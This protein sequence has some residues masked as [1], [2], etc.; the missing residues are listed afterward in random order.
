MV[1][2]VFLENS[3]S[4]EIEKDNFDLTKGGIEEWLK[5]KKII[6]IYSKL[7]S[8]KDVT[9]WQRGGAE[10]YLTKFS[11]SYTFKNDLIFKNILIKALVTINPENAL[12]DWYNRREY[13]KKNNVKVSNWYWY[14]NGIIIEDFYYYSYQ[15]ASLFDLIK[16]AKTID[17][18]GFKTTNFL[19][20]IMCDINSVPYY[21]D[22]GF[23]LG[24]YGNANTNDAINLLIQKNKSKEKEIILLLKNL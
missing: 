17:H 5:F 14:G 7:N 12:V 1:N 3:A 23:D 9:K 4:S 13:L 21:I 24:N 20:D 15:K 22:F 2:L 8:Y 11:F 19:E 6:P 10:T 18:L 16:I